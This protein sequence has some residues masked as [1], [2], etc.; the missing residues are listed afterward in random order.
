MCIRDRDTGSITCFLNQIGEYSFDK[1]EIIAVSQENFDAQARK[2]ENNRLN[3]SEYGNNRVNGTINSKEG[4][5]LFLSILYHDGWQIYVDG[6]KIEQKY[7][8]NAAFTGVE[9]SPGKH[10]IEL[11]YRPIGFHFS[12]ILLLSGVVIIVLVEI[13]RRRQLR[14]E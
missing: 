7:L 1:I 9:V 12:I 2:L 8:V 3:I 4:G 6:E 13:Y 10:K 5:I 11:L 14:K